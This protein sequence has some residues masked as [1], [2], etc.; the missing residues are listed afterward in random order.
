[1]NSKGSNSKIIVIS[2]NLNMGITLRGAN[3]YLREVTL[4]KSMFL[5]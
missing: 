3:F 1:M 2:V 5:E 4:E